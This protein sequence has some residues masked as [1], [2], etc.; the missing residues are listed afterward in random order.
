[1]FSSKLVLCTWSDKG[2]HS[3][4]KKKEKKSKPIKVARKLLRVHVKHGAGEECWTLEAV[5]VAA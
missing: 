5:G 3:L 1:M 4:A 2:A